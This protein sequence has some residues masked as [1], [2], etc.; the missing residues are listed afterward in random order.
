MYDRMVTSDRNHTLKWCSV[1]NSSVSWSLRVPGRECPHCPT[2]LPEANASVEPANLDPEEVAEGERL[3]RA[4]LSGYPTPAQR[5]K[6][7][8]VMKGQAER[9]AEE[10]QKWIAG[11]RDLIGDLEFGG[12]RL[13]FDSR[14][15]QKNKAGAATGWSI[16]MSCERCHERWR[17]RLLSRRRGLS[18]DRPCAGDT[19]PS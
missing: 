17:G 19:S 18:T 4:G 16:A 9:R 1:T 13:R 14:V 5:V 10:E 6:E 12:H 11:H 15:A 8:R 7:D 3:R 2:I